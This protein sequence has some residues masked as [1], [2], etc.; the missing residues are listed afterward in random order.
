[1]SFDVLVWVVAL[2]AVAG[3]A[4]MFWAGKLWHYEYSD[5]PITR[6][7]R[8]RK[9]TFGILMGFC[10]FVLLGAFTLMKPPL[11]FEWVKDH[12]SAVAQAQAEDKLIFIDFWAGWCQ[13]CNEIERQTFGR[14][15]FLKVLE[16]YVP[17]KVDLTDPGEAEEVVMK[18][19]EAGDNLPTFVLTT[20]DGKRR[21]ML[22]PEALGK[23][24]QTERIVSE[25][26]AFAEGAG[27]KEEKSAFA[28]ALAEGMLFALIAALLGG[29][30]TSLTPCVYPMIPITVSIIGSSAQGSKKIA[31]RNS[32]VYVGGIAICY[33][34]LGVVVA[35]VGGQFGALFQSPF[36]L[37]GVA[38]LM[39]LLAGHMLEVRK[40]G[41]LLRL[42]GAA[43]DVSGKGKGLGGIF[44]MGALAGFIFAPCV[45]PIL[46]GVLTYIGET[47]DVVLGF[48]FMFVFAIGM[49]APFIVLGTFSGLVAA[50]PGDWM[51]GVEAGFG[52]ALVAAALYFLAPIVPPLTEV[53]VLIAG[54]AT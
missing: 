33:S 28:K 46:L 30:A 15:E 44:L 40:L 16:N 25:L 27:L 14:E 35:S 26:R 32:V 21:K 8:V 49:G 11:S 19:Y 52:A 36:F 6:A 17:L 10:L 37:I 23:G 3:S 24:D 4:V 31:F 18:R 2:A 48:L 42:Q 45:G 47:G 50:R 1:M 5:P 54:L 38:V 34:L 51:I 53:F 43:G 9:T 39:L 29:L 13:R 22:D 41:F 12:D 7:G 20:A